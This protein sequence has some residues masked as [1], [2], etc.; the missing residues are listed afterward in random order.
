MISILKDEIAHNDPTQASNNALFPKYA[1]YN[2]NELKLT[3]N[4]TFL[5]YLLTVS[6]SL[7]TVEVMMELKQQVP[8]PA[9]NCFY[10]NWEIVTLSVIIWC[11]ATEK[12]RF[13]DAA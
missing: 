10:P 8:L 1:I 12:S 4:P 9:A 7:S 13:C 3:P 11:F 5:K 2:A 6:D